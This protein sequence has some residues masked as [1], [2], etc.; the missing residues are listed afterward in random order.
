MRVISGWLGG[1]IF[2]APRGHKTHPM[3]DKMRGGLFSA[4]GD[5]KG[6]TLIDCFGGSGALAIEAVSRGVKHAITVDNDTKAYQV[7]ANNIKSLSIDDR[8]K[9]VRANISAWS[10]RHPNDEFDLVVCDPPYDDIQ[11]KIIR[12]LPKHLA[13]NGVFVLSLP[14]DHDSLSL[15]GLKIAK[16]KNYGDSQL[17]FYKTQ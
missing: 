10:N 17:I 5:I 12:K 6:L 15:E 9:A 2:E 14:G 11:Y 3:S 1:R 7:A 13:E 8:C 4:L 16:S